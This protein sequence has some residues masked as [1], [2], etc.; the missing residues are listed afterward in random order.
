MAEHGLL[1]SL[2]RHRIERSDPLVCRSLQLV[3]ELPGIVRDKLGTV[4]RPSH[5]HVE[6]PTGS[7]I[8]GSVSRCREFHRLRRS[9]IEGCCTFRENLIILRNSTT[10]T[11][12]SRLA[13]N[14]MD[15]LSVH[16]SLKL[17]CMAARA[18]QTSLSRSG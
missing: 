17:P 14:S 11:S 1:S 12:S 3:G 15:L 9:L 7:S 13:M 2:L 4:S 16:T 10:S 18:L 8:A 6:R 5:R